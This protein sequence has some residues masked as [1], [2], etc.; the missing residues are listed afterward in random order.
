[1]RYAEAYSF[2]RREIGDPRQQLVFSLVK[3][4]LGA[5]PA[6]HAI[7][8]GDPNDNEGIDELRRY[9]DEEMVKELFAIHPPDITILKCWQFIWHFIT[10]IEVT[11]SQLSLHELERRGVWI[12][13]N[14]YRKIERFREPERIIV[15]Y[16]IDQRLWTLKEPW[17]LWAP[18][19]VLL[20]HRSD[21]WLWQG[22]TRWAE[23]ERYLAFPLDIFRTSWRELLGYIRWLGGEAADPD[24]D[25]LANFMWLG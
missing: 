2:Y 1:M 12:E 7:N 15:A 21:A 10:L 5:E 18:G 11:G 20:K 25:N 6:W 23:K 14:K 8:T 13:Y 4:T 22:R 24:P 16:V 19:P 3:L 9:L 17:L